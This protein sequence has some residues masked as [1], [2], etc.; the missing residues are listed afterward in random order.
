METINKK[1]TMVESTI[2]SEVYNLPPSLPDQSQKNDHK[3]R[4]NNSKRNQFSKG[5]NN[6]KATECTET[7]VNELKSGNYECMICYDKIG[8]RANIWSCSSCYALF[9]IG[10]INK[11]SHS[12]N[13]QQ[14]SQTWHCPGCRS[15][16]KGKAKSKCF[17][18]KVVK[19]KFD[20]YL[21]PHSCGD[22]CHR[23]R[24]GTSCPHMCTLICHPGPCPPCP[25]MGKLLHCFCKKS[26][27][28][29]RCG[30]NDPGKCC[31]SICDKTLNCGIHKCKQTCHAGPCDDCDVLINR[32]CYCGKE[33]KQIYCGIESQDATSLKRGFYSCEISCNELLSCGN[34][35]CESLCHKGQCS[36]CKTDTSL[37]HCPCGSS[38]LKKERKSCLD[39]FETCQNA[40]NKLLSCKEHRCKE[41]CHEG[42]CQECPEI[43]TAHCRCSSTQHKVSCAERNNVDLLCKKSCD[44]KKICGKHR[45]NKV[46]CELKDFGPEAHECN[47]PCNKLL[48]CKL[49]KCKANCHKGRCLPCPN[50]SF[51]ELACPCGRTV[52]FPPILCGTKPPVCT[53]PCNRQHNCD[54]PIAHPCHPDSEDCPK[55]VV[56]VSKPCGCSREVMPHVQCHVAYPS[57]GNRC[58]QLLSCG[59]HNC[60]KVCHPPGECQSLKPNS[61]NSSPR[62][63]F[64]TCGSKCGAQLPF[65]SHTCNAP[66]HPFE[67]CPSTICQEVITL[68]CSC[69]FR[70]EN[71]K[72]LRS[73]S[74]PDVTTKRLTCNDL[75]L[76]RARQQKLAAA[77]GKPSPT[78]IDSNALFQYSSFLV[79]AAS[80]SPSFVTRLEHCFSQ[81]I[82]SDYSTCRISKIENNYFRFTIHQL[83]LIYKLKITDS[84]N[85]SI[86]VTKTIE[87]CLP[88]TPLYIIIS[89]FPIPKQPGTGIGINTKKPGALLF[90]D[91]G[92]SCKSEHLHGLLKL[93]RAEYFLKWLDGET[94][95]ASF[96][97]EATMKVA[98]YVL[99]TNRNVL[100]KPISDCSNLCIEF[101]IPSVE[102]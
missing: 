65:C 34:H 85:S 42:E 2:K 15:E 63:H 90:Y 4:N 56:L 38:L 49:H 75:C 76:L 47:L 12:E 70:K 89:Q 59:I 46:C 25:A 82:K 81:L 16:N 66:C 54:H 39:S 48:S 96:N 35:K 100:V 78:E 98:A 57:C 91:L 30:E 31:G 93:Y 95:V 19:P 102:L 53:H 33:E 29:L 83:A 67:P 40:C 37:K 3:K 55:C 101:E 32:N 61:P 36:P 74:S 64:P 44:S 80:I 17:C 72:C 97:D 58:N 88:D 94:A 7:L 14:E 51:D 26:T 73:E 20:A 8:K 87:S 22:P 43:I 62:E 6:L 77:F 71:G 60:S 52:I 84:D 13:N 45:C 41:K 5:R 79:T 86:L 23:K 21:T 68:T 9:H 10:C 99:S 1:P 28:R 24:E 92:A 11:W 27:Y 50:V 69:G 18:G